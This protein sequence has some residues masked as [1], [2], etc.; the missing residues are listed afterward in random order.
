MST[1]M[2]AN[3]RAMS[4]ESTNLHNYN[5]I[6]NDYFVDTTDRGTRPTKNITRISFQ[7]IW[8]IIKRMISIIIL[9]RLK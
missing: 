7:T 8:I 1:K 2:R 6:E 9:Y 5:G 4:N 3:I